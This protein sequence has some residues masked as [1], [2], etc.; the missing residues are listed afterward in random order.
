MMNVSG[1]SASGLFKSVYTYEV[2]KSAE[3]VKDKKEPYPSG[4][5]VQFNTEARARYEQ[6]RNESTSTYEP[7]STELTAEDKRSILTRIQESFALAK[8]QEDDTSGKKHSI[9]QSELDEQLASFDSDNATDEE[10]EALFQQVQES[11]KAMRP[12]MPRV[13][14]PSMEEVQALEEMLAPLSS[15]EASTDEEAD[16]EEEI[17]DE[18]LDA[19]LSTYDGESSKKEY[20]EKL[21]QVLTDYFYDNEDVPVTAAVS[22]L[23]KLDE[24]S[25]ESE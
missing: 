2:S 24:W 4:D 9:E 8:E 25:A 3:E 6:L 17:V 5:S 1:S 11:L 22:I 19:L 16:S 23:Q 21:K 12:P 15:I 14:M 7:A 20:A 13:D 18:V 10:V